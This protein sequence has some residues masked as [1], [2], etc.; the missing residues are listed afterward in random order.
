MI[1]WIRSLLFVN[2]SKNIGNHILRF[3]FQGVFTLALLPYDPFSKIRRG[4]SAF[5]RFFDDDWF[6]S[7]FTNM[8][9][10]RVDV[11]ETQTDVI[12]AAEIP[13]LEKKEDVNIVVHNNHLHI[14]GKIEHV[15]EQKDENIHR[16]ERFYGQFSRTIP[17]PTSVEETGASASYRNGILEVRIPKSKQ[18]I[19]HKIDLD[20]Q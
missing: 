14:S 12:V 18:Q 6:N 17:L 13:G 11:K 16:T 4:F 9:S 15:D 5:P 7:H 2:I 8:P 1:N 20:F 10:V 19:G 3:I